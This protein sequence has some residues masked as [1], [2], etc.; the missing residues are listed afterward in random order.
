MFKVGDKVRW[1]SQARGSHT[2]KT[3]TVVAVVQGGVDPKAAHFLKAAGVLNL[4]RMFDGW[5]RHEV[6][7]LVTVRTGKTEKAAL[8]VYWPRTCLLELEE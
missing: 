3:G 8:K 5:P 6:S 4:S 1:S 2:K 7:Y